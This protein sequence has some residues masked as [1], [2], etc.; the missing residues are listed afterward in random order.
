MDGVLDTWESQLTSTDH[1][2]VIEVIS[3]SGPSHDK[4]MVLWFPSNPI[5]IYKTDFLDSE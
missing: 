2:H 3:R 4:E 1:G 5:Y